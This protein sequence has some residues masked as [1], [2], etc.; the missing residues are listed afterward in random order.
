M[1]TGPGWKPLSSNRRMNQRA[2]GVAGQ[3]PWSLRLISLLVVSIALLLEMSGL[4]TWSLQTQR[5]E[6][7]SI[8]HSKEVRL[9]L[10]R[11]LQLLTDAQVGEVAIE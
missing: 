10:L 1:D 11:I 8:A 2:A 4:A 5:I 3:L 7:A 9:E 6:A